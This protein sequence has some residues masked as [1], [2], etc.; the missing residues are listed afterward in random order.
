MLGCRGLIVVAFLF[1]LFNTAHGAS[2]DKVIAIVND[3]V[4]TQIELDDRLRGLRAEIKSRGADAPPED[5]LRKQLLERMINDRLQLQAADRLGIEVSEKE[6]DA[7]VMTVAQNNRMTLRQLREALAQQ[8]IP[9]SLFRESIRTDMLINQIFMRRIRNSVLVTEDE[10]NNF[11]A[12]GGGQA[13]AREYDVSHILIRVPEAASS[14]DVGEARRKAEEAKSRLA[15]GMSFAEAAATYSDAP[16]ALEGGRLGW[17][18]PRQLP[19]L[20]TE[21]LSRIGVG[22]NTEVLESANGFHI[23]HINDA[24]GVN[25]TS[26]TQTHV[27][28]IL[29]RTDEFLSDSEA[30]HRLDQLR[31][32]ILNGEDFANLARVHSD[33]TVSAAKG[34][35][36]G[37][38]N[39]GEMV[40]A[41][42]DVM[43][44]LQPGEI[45]EPVQSPYGFHI[46]EVL[47]R[48]QKNMGEEATRARA[49]AQLV[50][51]KSDERYEQWLRRLRDESFVEI[52]EQ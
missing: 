1:L 27:R 14:N 26:V 30:Q 32:R 43:G 46:I 42:E 3:D 35:E 8:G 22:Q 45:S 16:D 48:R 20:F 33:D 4:I 2:V 23:L 19:E 7:A 51:Q 12:R 34:G 9:Y 17:R 29:M 41:F 47:D 31:E 39:P 36:L 13:D 40:P 50:A 10:L 37:W 11:I 28:H 52:L 21:A 6:L 5:V 15:Q 24:R 49:R 18:E 38:V 25:T 44:K